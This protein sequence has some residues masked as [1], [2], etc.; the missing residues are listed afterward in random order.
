MVAQRHSTLLINL[1]CGK[2]M[3]QTNIQKLPYCSCPSV[4]KKYDI[5]DSKLLCFLVLIL[6][7]VVH[8]YDSYKCFGKTHYVFYSMIILS[9]LYQNMWTWYIHL[10]VN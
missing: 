1:F 10:L 3:R 7:I 5:V 6:I 2:T 8:Q 9:R 4:M